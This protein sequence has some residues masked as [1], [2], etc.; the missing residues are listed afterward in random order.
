MIALIISS[1]GSEHSDSD[2]VTLSCSVTTFGWCT[3]RVKW[4]FKGQGITDAKTK[5]AYCSTSV[6]FKTS[7]YIHTSGSGSLTCE[8]TDIYTG[9]VRVFTFGPQSSGED[10]TSCSLISRFISFW[11]SC[12]TEWTWGPCVFDFYCPGEDA[13]TVRTTKESPTA[14]EDATKPKGREWILSISLSFLC[15]VEVKCMNV[16]MTPSIHFQRT[17]VPL[18]RI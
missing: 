3:Q 13:T 6:T 4:L 9:S 17:H 8:A 15:A 14:V 16:R 18:F 2:T 7:H 10:L 11:L 1:P 12:W 5:Q